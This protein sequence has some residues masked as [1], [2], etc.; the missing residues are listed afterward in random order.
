VTVVGFYKTWF[1]PNRAIMMTSSINHP[2]LEKVLVTA[3]QN[4][5]MQLL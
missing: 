5:T 4:L 1:P 2:R 3:V